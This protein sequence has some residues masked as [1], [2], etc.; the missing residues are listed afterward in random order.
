VTVGQP[1]PM[2]ER[3]AR[4]L[5][6]LAARGLPDAVAYSQALANDDARRADDVDERG[7]E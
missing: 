7:H 5:A 1:P 3:A 6:A 4:V 2:P